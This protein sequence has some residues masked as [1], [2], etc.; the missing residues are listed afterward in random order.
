MPAAP[1]LDT[2]E[3]DRDWPIIGLIGTGHFL[4]H[5]YMLC[6]APLFLLWKEE[7]GVSFTTL[8]LSIA[9][10]STVTAV[11]QTPVVFLVDRHGARR[12]LVGGTLLMACPSRPWPS[13]PT[14]AP[15]WRCRCCRA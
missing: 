9:L 10:M 1:T 3:R 8:G 14:S 12:F 11:L 5:F 7:F 15:S 13:P 4:S 2:P 6:L